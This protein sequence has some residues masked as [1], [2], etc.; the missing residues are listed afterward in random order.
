MAKDLLVSVAIGAVLQGSYLAAF[1]GAKRTLETLDATSAKLKKQHDEMGAAMKRAVGTLSGGSLAALNRDYEKLGRTIDALRQK[2]EKLAASMARGVEL[3]TARQEHVSGI[4]E[5][6]ATAVAIGA[7]F[8]ASVKQSAK[9]EAGLRDIAITGNLKAKD[10]IALGETLRQAALSTNQGHEAI[11]QGVN[12]LVAQGMNAT[13]AGK[14]ASL[15]GKTSTATGA[16]MNDLAKMMYSLSNNLDIKGEANLKEAL[17]RAAYGAK[18]GQF[19]L[20]AMAS[21]LPSLASTFAAKGIKGQE[22]LTQIIAS[23][24]VGRG[25][26]GTDGEAVTNLVNWMSHMNTDHTTKAYQKAGVDYQKSMQKMVADGYSSY[27]ASLQIADK[28]ITGKGDA[29]MAEWKKAGEKGDESAQRQL[30]ES[31]GLN[32]VFTDIQTIN[33]LLA[34]RQNW[35]KYQQNKKDMGSQQALGTIDEDYIRRAQTMQKA[36]E[37]FTTQITDVAITVGAAFLPALSDMLDG[38]AP[39]VRGFGEWAKANPDVLRGIVGLV[40]GM[41]ALRTGIFALRFLGNFMFLAPANSVA[42]AWGVLSSRFAIFRTLVTGGASRFSLLLQLFGMGAD[43]AAKLAV[44]FGKLGGWALSLGKSLAGGLL[45]GIRLAGQAVLWLGR[46]LMMNPIGLAVTAIGLAVTA[47]GVAAYL[48]WKNWDKVK[49]AVMAGWNWMK[50]MKNQF[51]SAG[52]D[53]I[54]GLVNGVT[55]K[56]TAARDSIVSFGS[57]I[58]GWFASTLGIKSPSR[59]FMGF[60]DN[61]A[62]GAALGVTRSSALAGKAVAGMALATATAWGKPQLAAPLV[63]LAGRVGSNQ[64]A[65]RGPAPAGSGGMVI[66]FSPQITIQGGDPAAMRGQVNQAMQL[67]FTEFERMMKRYEHEKGRTTY[68]RNA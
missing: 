49:G 12:T 62:Q 38:L 57:S 37:R 20:K 28:F 10:E 42:T 22:A 14:Y 63:D 19:E 67:S 36:W 47:I 25:A 65:Q 15:L 60:G 55:S 3:K 31:F 45:T 54:N 1:S 16:E 61:I 48:V 50:G 26:A 7:P 33:H 53:L 4:K 27:E 41:V 44:W 68:G 34:M 23:L 46:A 32:E 40:G 11:M 24:E 17:N 58:K 30:M 8:L 29:F 43:R 9:F 13:E 56:L 18:L 35:D 51:F 6:A 59:V 52:A 39:V 21:A 2:Q 5:S 66:H 64:V